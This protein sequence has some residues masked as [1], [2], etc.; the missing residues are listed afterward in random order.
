MYASQARMLAGA[1]KDIDL[2]P[3]PYDIQGSYE[4]AKRA[5]E[6]KWR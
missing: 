6:L 2:P 5:A 3:Q 1:P 4:R